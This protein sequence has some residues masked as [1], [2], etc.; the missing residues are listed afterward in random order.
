MY[1]HRVLLFLFILTVIH[2]QGMESTTI[3][4]SQ[5]VSKSDYER[6]PSLKRLVLKRLAERLVREDDKTLISSVK[7]AYPSAAS[8]CA[9][10]L[11]EEEL[12]VLLWRLADNNRRTAQ[13]DHR[14]L[15]DRDLPRDESWN[16]VEVAAFSPDN[17]YLMTVTSRV[18]KIN[19]TDWEDCC[20]VYVWSISDIEE[21]M[22]AQGPLEPS[23]ESQLKPLSEFVFVVEDRGIMFPF[24]PKVVWHPASSMVALSINYGECHLLRLNEGVFSSQG[25]IRAVPKE[26]YVSFVSLAFDTSGRRLLIQKGKCLFCIDLEDEDQWPAQNLLDASA[27]I[28]DDAFCAA[29]Y[30]DGRIL[31]INTKD[32]M[33]TT[34]DQS[35]K[36]LEKKAL[37][38]D[39]ADDF[40]HLNPDNITFIS[41]AQKVLLRS[42]LFKDYEDG[43]RYHIGERLDVCSLHDGNCVRPLNIEDV[44]FHHLDQRSLTMQDV[45]FYYLDQRYAL[46]VINGFKFLRINL[47]DLKT[48]KSVIIFQW[49]KAT[50][51]VINMSPLRRYVYLSTYDI[52]REKPLPFGPSVIDIQMPFTDGFTF[53]QLIVLAKMNFHGVEE[54]LKDPAYKAIYSE[55]MTSSPYKD[56]IKLYFMA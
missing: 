16:N 19:E 49:R 44:L 52:K 31:Y 29:W 18:N 3:P 25:F 1:S 12:R 54:V 7:E 28:I 4:S 41:K 9:Q 5:D 14:S 10:V 15:N 55:I 21:N 43:G 39:S 45:H 22:E 38:L 26:E 51:P 6:V 46:H 48:L 50:G 36:V 37:I 53:E 13:L 32:K 17:R 33:L 27:C 42:I 35:G 30:P 24:Y 34:I 2:L 40:K 11:A 47:C 8:Q 56:K 23:K 20:V